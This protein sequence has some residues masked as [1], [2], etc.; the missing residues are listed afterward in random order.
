[1]L[2]V[3]GAFALIHH[4]ATAGLTLS[5]LA[6]RHREIVAGYLLAVASLAVTGA[7]LAALV[8]A[9]VFVAQWPLQAQLRAGDARGH[10]RATEYA[11]MIAMAAAFWGAGR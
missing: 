4:G 2:V 6:A 7:T 8:V 5:E 9:A 1:V 11:A 10:F 3:A